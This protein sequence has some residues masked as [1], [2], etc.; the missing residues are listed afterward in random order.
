MESKEFCLKEG[1]LKVL[2]EH[3]LDLDSKIFLLVGE[4]GSGKST[5][6]QAFAS[7]FSARTCSPSFSFINEYDIGQ[8]VKKSKIYHYDFYFKDTPMHALEAFECLQNEGFH[9]LEW[10]E[11]LETNLTELG[12]K[13][14]KIKIIEKEEHSRIYTIEEV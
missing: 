5:L 9:F 13:F 7:C 2:C 11:V 14:A 12:F 10:G 8:A 6:V 4:V 3:M 1:E